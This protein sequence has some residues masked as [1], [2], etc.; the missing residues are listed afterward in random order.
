MARLRSA[1]RNSRLTL[2]LIVVAL[3]LGN[4]VPVHAQTSSS[5]TLVQVFPRPICGSYRDG[6]T[7]NR[8]VW[9][10]LTLSGT[11][12]RPV[13]FGLKNRP[14]GSTIVRTTFVN[15]NPVPYQPIA[16]GSGDGS[17]GALG[18]VEV[19]YHLGT[20]PP[21]TYTAT[22]WASDGVVTQTLPVTLVVKMEK[23][24]SY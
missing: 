22:L 6:S 24:S 4:L 15:G 10:L 13:A 5:W 21:G 3:L 11:W 1:V 2:A 9:I 19:T 12:T 20:T 18:R 17:G 8:T 16:P 14:P 7:P 23:C